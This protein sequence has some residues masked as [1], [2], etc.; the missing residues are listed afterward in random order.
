MAKH[1]ASK[2][3]KLYLLDTNKAELDKVVAE[4]AAKTEVKSKEF[5][6]ISVDTHEPYEAL[7]SSIQQECG[8]ISMLVN[9]IERRDPLVDRFQDT[10]DEELIKL[11]NV[12]SFPITFLTR[13]LG[14]G[15]KERTASKKKC[16]IVNML[17]SYSIYPSQ[18]MPVYSA[19]KGF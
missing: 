15:M 10:S 4:L 7:C 5:D 3:F 18:Y 17:G 14:P 11:L 1:L 8:D 13:F 2:G 6:F 12:N 9:N 19:S 16:A